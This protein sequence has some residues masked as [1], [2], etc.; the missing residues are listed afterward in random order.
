MADANI[1]IDLESYQGDAALAFGSG[2]AGGVPL[3]LN[4]PKTDEVLL[5]ITQ[6]AITKRKNDLD[7][8]Q[9]N[10]E[11]ALLKVSDTEGVYEADQ[12]VIRQKQKDLY[13]YIVENAD[14]IAPMASL[15]NTERYTEFISRL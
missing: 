8:F 7:K 11:S 2:F 15:K 6:N 5:S 3:S 10:I 1:G 12:Q 14:A 9:K 13:K 4:T